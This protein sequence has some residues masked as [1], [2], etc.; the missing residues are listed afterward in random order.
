MSHLIKDIWKKSVPNSTSRAPFPIFTLLRIV[1]TLKI[2]YKLFPWR[3]IL[4]LWGQE[5]NIIL[6]TSAKKLVKI[7]SLS[8]NL[9]LC[10]L[11][12]KVSTCTIL[13]IA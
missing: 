4:K 7:R 1:A 12:K 2:R 9:D 13:E 3:N 6:S 10:L 8:P 5:D 11:K